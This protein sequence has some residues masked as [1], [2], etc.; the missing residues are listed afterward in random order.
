MSCV[1]LLMFCISHDGWGD[2][3]MIKTLRSASIMSWAVFL[4]YMMYE[5]TLITAR[6]RST[7]EGNVL[8][9]VCLSVHRGLP[10]SRNALQHFPECHRAAGGG[11]TLPGPVGGY[12]A[13]SS[14]GGYPAG[15]YPA[16][17]YPGWGGTLAGGYPGWGV[18]W[19]GVPW[20]GVPCLGGYPVRTT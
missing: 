7:R 18:P 8:T 3:D 14:Q 4:W 10:V 6:V 17:G 15:G 19:L 13:R 20:P 9:R 16:R 11:G 1:L 12:P 2:I 5:V